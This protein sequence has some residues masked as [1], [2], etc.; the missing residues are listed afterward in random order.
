[1]ARCPWHND[2]R[3]SLQVNPQRQTWKC[4]V[5]NI[6][7]DVFSYVMQRDGVE[8]GEALKTLAEKAGIE[9]QPGSRKKATPGSP[10]DKAALQAALQFARQRVL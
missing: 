8:F 7:G 3:P 9:L 10:S 2:K 4:W 6:G 5:C 1:M